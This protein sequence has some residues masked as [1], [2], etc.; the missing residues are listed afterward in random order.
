MGMGN[1]YRTSVYRSFLIQGRVIWALLMREILTRY[2]RHNIG[3]MWM[4]AEPMMFTLGVIGLW[5]LTQM[6]HT[7]IPLISFAIT[8]YSAVLLWRNM[9]SRTSGAIPPNLGL[10]FHRNV[11]VIDIYISRILLEAVGATISFII[12]SLFFI[13]LGL[14]P[15]PEDILKVIFGWIMLAWFGGALAIVIGAASEMSEMIEKVWHPITY[16]IFPLSGAMIMVEWLP[17]NLQHII[18]L[19]PMVHGTEILRE[20]Y[21]GSTVTAHYDMTYMATVNLCMTLVGLA[22]TREV[23]RR[24][25]PE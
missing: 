17:L 18:L 16:L 25:T 20:G 6:G 4:F 19:L 7:D 14:M 22:L 3:F 12:L 24:V 13:A 21:F 2:G 23:G 15:L 1:V 11:H 10:M 9:P 8:G 5:S